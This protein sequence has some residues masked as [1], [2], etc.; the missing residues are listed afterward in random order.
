MQSIAV[1]TVRI[2]LLAGAFVTALLASFSASAEKR[3]ALVVGNN[4][5]DSV[6]KLEKAV[7]DA[8]AVSSSL[9][10]LG[11]QVQLA[12]DLGRRDFIRQLSAFMDRVGPGDL[13][14]FYYAG[15]GIEVRGVNYILP[16]DVPPVMQGQE[17]LLTGEAVPTEKIISDLQDR[18]ARATVFVLDACRDNPFKT[19]TTRSLGGARGLAQGTP[20][21]GVFVLYSAGVG[22]SA[23]DRMSDNDPDP[24]SVFTRV[25]LKEIHKKDNT[26][27]AIA[28]SVQVAVRDL[29]QTVSHTQVP[30][31][32]DQIIGQLYIA[33]VGSASAKVD[34]N[35]PAAGN[36]MSKQPAIANVPSQQQLPA[37]PVFN[38]R[39]FSEFL[40]KQSQHV[41]AAH[42]WANPNAV[43]TCDRLA[44]YGSDVPDSRAPR[45][46]LKDISV[47]EAVP[48][49]IAAV[50]QDSA[51]PR[52]RAQLAR[53]L[54]QSP[55]KTDS[56]AGFNILLDLA[57]DGYPAAMWR[58]GVTYSGSEIKKDDREAAVWFR[59]A[60]DKGL[61]AAMS[62]LAYKYETG[63]G[64]ARD[65][66]EAARW[67]ERAAASGH[68]SGMRN[69]ALVLDKGEAVGRNAKQ[70]AEYLLTAFRM[71][72][73]SAR[74]SL[75][76]LNGAWHTD[77]RAQVQELLKDFGFYKGRTD[78]EFDA[79]T[80]AALT[81]LQS[82]N[83]I[84]A[85]REE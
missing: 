28:K 66:R 4:A 68:P 54:L 58:I 55:S 41:R 63:E 42:N 56:Q 23:L 76:E 37:R 57:N 83:P 27:V 10:A 5:Y 15:H 64:V 39:A 69:Y 6:P 48:A 73:T 21:E 80:Y 26:L 14:L 30:A 9:Q 20:P 52:L 67:F 84:I 40:G 16:T 75:F 24:N 25:F 82:S 12:T 3:V 62:D 29:S 38:N 79:E 22:Q 74:K 51:T 36:T 2:I 44:S 17:S 43:A 60:A 72:S 47:K 19:G 61:G 46:A 45:V 53:A 81:A 8:K 13:A 71:G 18:G 50:L 70:S 32:Y 49:C 59:R 7:N 11:F 77:T 34:Q 85:G 65:Q 35:L 1:S 78:G 31:Y 33:S